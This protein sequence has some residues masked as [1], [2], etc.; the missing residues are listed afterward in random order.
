MFFKDA[1]GNVKGNDADFQSVT[2]RAGSFNVLTSQEFIGAPVLPSLTVA[3][4]PSVT[5]SAGKLVVC[6]NGA[7]GNPC[8][9]YCDGTKWYQVAIGAEVSAI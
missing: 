9:A 7:S 4:L 3:Q 2:S 5:A 8:L 6:S 1:K